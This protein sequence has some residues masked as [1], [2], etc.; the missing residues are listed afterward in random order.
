M[1]VEIVYCIHYQDE[2]FDWKIR[3]DD[4]VDYAYIKALFDALLGAH[5]HFR[6]QQVKKGDE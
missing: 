3:I 2:Q 1:V 6:L 4:G 5:V